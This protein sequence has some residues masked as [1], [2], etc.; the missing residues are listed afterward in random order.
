MCLI[1][2]DDFIKQATQSIRD[3]LDEAVAHIFDTADFVMGDAVRN[4]E[5]H[6]CK[7]VGVKHCVGVNSGTSAL[8]LA[9]LVLG[10]GPGDEV[11]IP[12]NT[13][14]A[15]SWGVSYVGATPVFVDIERD[16]H[17]TI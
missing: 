9:M 6:F 1:P 12:A 15:T 10:I 8:H 3:E 17:N 11:I 16:T 5:E 14:I 4:F 2:P 7:Y 13:Y